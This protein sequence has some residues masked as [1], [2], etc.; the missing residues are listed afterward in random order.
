MDSYGI[1]YGVRAAEMWQHENLDSKIQI[2]SVPTER[3]RVFQKKQRNLHYAKLVLWDEAHMQ[4][5]AS[6]AKIFKIHEEQG[7]VNIGLTATPLGISELYS[8]LIVAGTNSDLRQCGAHLPCSVYAPDEPDLKKV[9]RNKTGEFQIA[10]KTYK[11]WT[12]TIVGRVVD[13]Y[14]R[15]NPERLPTI[16]FAPGVKESM[17]FVD[18]LK[19]AG[20]R[21]AH[22]DGNNVYQD[23]EEYQSSPDK[24]REVVDD[25]RAGRIDVICNR[26]VLRE[27]IDIPELYHCILAT[28]IGSLLSYLQTVGRVLR[29]HSSLDHVKIQDHGGNFWRHGS[30]N[31]NRDWERIWRLSD[32]QIT[33][34]RLDRMAEGKEPEPIVC[35]AC[36]AVRIKGPQCASCNHKHSKSVRMVVQENGT[37]KKQTG[38]IMKKKVRQER[39]D[40]EK[41]WTQYYFKAKNSQMTFSQA[42]GLFKR[43]LGY[44][45]PRDL[46]YMPK[47]DFDRKRKVKD[48][49]AQSLIGK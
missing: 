5:A 32:V 31:W 33:N 23:G 28:P 1:D 49:P 19:E 8:K 30:P 27:G 45:P 13:Y 34:T 11:I 44:W 18:Q 14:H 20:I 42:E 22:I 25:L 37:L 10:E 39:S 16:L 17:W 6:A 12:Q 47:D 9:K 26:F 29:N 35:P 3:S 40:T 46:P 36:G 2:A 43:E 21:A 7:A 4:K 38:A 41:K 15:L 24:R 48:V